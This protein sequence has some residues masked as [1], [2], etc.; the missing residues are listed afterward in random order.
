MTGDYDEYANR[1]SAEELIAIELAQRAN[2]HERHRAALKDWHPPKA[3]VSPM[4][5][6]A[7]VILPPEI[8]AHLNDKRPEGRQPLSRGA[9]SRRQAVAEYGRQRI[10]EI[11]AENKKQAAE[12]IVQ[13]RALPTGHRRTRLEE[14]ARDL[15]AERRTGQNRRTNADPIKMRA[16]RDARDFAKE[17]YGYT[18]KI[19]YIIR[20]LM[21]AKK[22]QPT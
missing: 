20:H 14:R 6:D 7:P 19:D 5:I 8:S 11:V 17:R 16:A 22:T 13:A 12:L 1:Q 21:D 2:Y 18:F 9:R 4:L 15:L 10:E 3:L